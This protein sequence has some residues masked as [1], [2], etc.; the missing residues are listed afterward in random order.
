LKRCRCEQGC[1][2]PYKAEEMKSACARE[3]LANQVKDLSSARQ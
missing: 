1:Q 2:E 3:I